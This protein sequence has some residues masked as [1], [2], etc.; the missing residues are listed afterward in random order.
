[1][2]L[3]MLVLT[4]TPWSPNDLKSLTN[5]ISI[6]KNEGDCQSGLDKPDILLLLPHSPMTDNNVQDEEM[7]FKDIKSIATKKKIYIAG[8][9]VLRAKNESAPQ[10]IGFLISNDGQCLLRVPKISPD[11]I[12]GFTNT[13]SALGEKANFPVATLPF[14]KVGLLCGEDIHFSQYSRVLAFNGAEI[15]LNPSI[16]KSDHQYDHRIMSRFARASESLSYVAVDSTSSSVS[17]SSWSDTS[18]SITIAFLL[19]LLLSLL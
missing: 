3:V 10:T 16:E 11:L 15:I 5:L 4:Q 18:P 1:M 12:E 7:F 6:A 13:T 2:E 19:L 14:A 8:S 9:A 17:Y